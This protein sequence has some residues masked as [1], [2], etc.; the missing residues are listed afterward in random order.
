M[1]Q[2]DVLSGKKAGAQLVARRFP[3]RVGRA[4]ENEIRL[5][6]DGVWDQHCVVQIKGREGF[7]VTAAGNALM[8]VNSHPVQSAILRN[9]DLIE[10]GSVKLRF[11]LAPTR[12]R[13]LKF[14]E[15]LVWALLVAVVLSQFGLIYWLLL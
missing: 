10:L 9:G 7:A 4:V 15:G 3:V 11:W 6:E 13:G 8:S 1:I 5:E 2:F 12:R 14:R